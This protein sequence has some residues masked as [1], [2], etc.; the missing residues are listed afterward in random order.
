VARHCEGRKRRSNP[1]GPRKNTLDC[2][3]CA[4]NDDKVS[5]ALVAAYREGLGLAAVTLIARETGAR[6]MCSREEPVLGVGEAVRA[7]WWCKSVQQAEWLM[8]AAMRATQRSDVDTSSR[9]HQ[10]L[11]AAKRLGIML[12]SDEKVAR[13]ALA[14]IARLEQEIAAQQRAGALKSVNRG[15]RDYRL[16]ASARGEKVLRYA[17]WICSEHLE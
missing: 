10:T 9:L 15:Y 14:V 4:R 1:D 5:D 3:A 8:Q 12:R 6:L 17:D 16:A 2:F 13:E 7:R 11:N